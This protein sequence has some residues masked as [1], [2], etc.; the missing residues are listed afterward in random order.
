MLGKQFSYES[1]S[2]LSQEN[3]TTNGKLKCLYIASAGTSACKTSRIIAATTT[4][5]TLCTW[6]SHVRSFFHYF[7]GDG[8]WQVEKERWGKKWLRAKGKR[9]GKEGGSGRRWGFASCCFPYDSSLFL[10]Q[11]CSAL[12]SI[13]PMLPRLCHIDKG[14]QGPV[15]G[16][17]RIPLILNPLPRGEG[18]I[19]GDWESARREEHLCGGTQVSIYPA[20]HLCVFICVRVHAEERRWTIESPLQPGIWS[21]GLQHQFKYQ[22]EPLGRLIGS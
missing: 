22:E 21:Q 9:R 16:T 12:P 3:A 10:P 17:I 11:I 4:A 18:N 19:N 14:S 7:F 15:E 2:R 1:C 5:M 13:V 8:E 6:Q 20:R